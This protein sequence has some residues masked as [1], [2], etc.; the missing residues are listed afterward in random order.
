MKR[1]WKAL[2]AGALTLAVMALGLAGPAEAQMPKSGKINGSVG[3]TI[4]GQLYQFGEEVFQHIGTVR[5]FF[6]STPSGGML[7]QTSYV[8]TFDTEMRSGQERSQ[9]FCT[10]TDSQGD[11]VHSEWTAKR[12]GND[13]WG[14]AVTLISG[15]GKYK[16]IQGKGKWVLPEFNNFRASPAGDHQATQVEGYSVWDVD[17]RLP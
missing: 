9:G 12:A 5:G 4:Q 11:K 2:A 7:D 10:H 6:V 3:W 16:G 8:C 17:Y 15:T 1:M 14:G 13:K